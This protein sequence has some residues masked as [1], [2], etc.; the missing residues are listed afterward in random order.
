MKKAAAFAR[1]RRYI[2]TR[3]YDPD[4]TPDSVLRCKPF[5]V[6]FTLQDTSRLATADW[7][8]GD[9]ASYT[10]LPL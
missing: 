7:N 10:D 6:H 8:F 9:G 4:L 1:A 3:L 5:T 2:E